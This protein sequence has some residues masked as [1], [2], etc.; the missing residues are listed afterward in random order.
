MAKWNARAF[1]TATIDFEIEA[2]DPDQVESRVNEY[3]KHVSGG[4]PG[5]QALS[6]KVQ[7]GDENTGIFIMEAEIE[8][9]YELDTV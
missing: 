5:G 7:K 4:K 8:D 3:L 6:V 9:V 2:D 1:V